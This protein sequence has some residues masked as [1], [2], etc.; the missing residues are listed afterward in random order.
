MWW[1]SQTSF[2]V[3]MT[4]VFTSAHDQEVSIA[5]LRDR[6]SEID[7]RHGLHY[8]AVTSSL[9]LGRRVQ[10]EALANTINVTALAKAFV[11]WGRRTGGR[12][13]NLNGG[14]DDEGGWLLRACN[15]LP[16]YTRPTSKT[17]RD[18]KI[19]AWLVRQAYIRHAVDDPLD[20]KIGRAWIMF[21][22]LVAEGGLRV[23]NPSAELERVIGVNAE[24][25]WLLGMA[26]WANQVMNPT[27]DGN[28]WLFMPS[29]F[30]REGPNQAEINAKLAR[31]ATNIHDPGRVCR[32]VCR[33]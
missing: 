14:A 27:A 15:T 30:V 28:K 1:C 5:Q 3:P 29:H 19:V 22:N 18:E 21:H 17:D 16:W 24:Y 12:P 26:I 20:A 33:R 25:L 11:L 31:A 6:V 32:S 10:H 9:V 8:L 13:L 7:L 23:P 2:E 4:T